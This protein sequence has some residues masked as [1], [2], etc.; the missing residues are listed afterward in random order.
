M[1]VL[2]IQQSDSVIHIR[3]SV[4]FQ[5]LFPDGKL[6]ILHI[7]MHIC[8]SVLFQILFPDGKLQNYYTVLSR[9]PCTVSLLMICFI[10]RIV[11]VLI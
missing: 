7:R 3:L 11:R 1:L 6:Q 8:I 2:A 9:V 4:L 5:I 10:Y